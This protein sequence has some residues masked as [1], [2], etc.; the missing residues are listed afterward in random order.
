MMKKFTSIGLIFIFFAT[1]LTACSQ[2]MDSKRFISV[3]ANKGVQAQVMNEPDADGTTVQNTH[4][5]RFISGQRVTFDL[6]SWKEEAGAIEYFTSQ[7]DLYD[8]V[9]EGDGMA[10]NVED[11]STDTYQKIIANMSFVDDDGLNSGLYS[12]LIREGKQ[13][14]TIN[15]IGDDP[16]IVLFVDE[17]VK[18]LGYAK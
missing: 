14:I 8:Y 17:V 9:L 13:V 15:A 1:L 7:Q 5:E 2:K 11:K 12:V 18:D 6:S 4:G 3:L 16:S 10:G